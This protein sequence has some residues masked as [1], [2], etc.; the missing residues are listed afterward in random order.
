MNPDDR[1]QTANEQILGTAKSR[2][3]DDWR[4]VIEEIYDARKTNFLL[5]VRKRLRS[6]G[7]HDPYD[8]AWDVLQECMAQ[9]CRR[10]PPQL[11]PPAAVVKYLYTALGWRVL[12]H[13]KR[14]CSVLSGMNATSMETLGADGPTAS[15]ECRISEYKDLLM[16]FYET[17]KDNEASIWN[18]HLADRLKGFDI[19]DEQLAARLGMTV[20]S[21]RVTRFRVI[22]KFHE[23]IGQKKRKEGKKEQKE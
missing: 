1:V 14:L 16:K 3:A 15:E 5:F 4:Q 6:V 12:D 22:A 2:T 17:L 18:Y 11:N 21:L 7:C 10:P 23:F 9:V 20:S 13:R 19:P 8:H